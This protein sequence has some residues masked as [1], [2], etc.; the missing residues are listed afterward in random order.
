MHREGAARWLYSVYGTFCTGT[1]SPHMVALLAG[2][3]CVL[4]VPV[5]SHLI[6]RRCLLAVCVY[7]LYSLTSYGGAAR[8]VYV[9]TFCTLSTHM[10]ALLAGCMCVLSVLS[11]LLW[12]RCS[13]AVQCVLSVLYYLI[14]RCCSLAV[15]VYFLYSLTSYGSAARWLAVC[16]F[17]T[18][19]PH[20]PALL[21]GCMCVLS[22]LFHLI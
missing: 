21:A 6:W 4:S 20:M 3:M 5:L 8:W 10:P 19:L 15:C 22:V 7:F 18:L 12:R 1:L 11:H 9:C 13:L 16:T 17:C 14:W 2:C